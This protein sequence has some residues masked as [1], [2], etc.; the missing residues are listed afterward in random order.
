MTDAAGAPVRTIFLGSG[1]FAVPILD[2]LAEWPGATIVGVVTTPARPAG[3][4][5]APRP[6]PIALRAEALGLPVLTPDRLRDPAAHA[7]IA[8]LRPDL[9]VL[10]DYGRIVP[11]AL[12]D[13][14]LHGALN[15]HPSLLPRHRG[16]TPIPA[17]IAAGDAQ[18][19]VSLMRMDAGVDTGPLIARTVV[20]LDGTERAPELERRL[21]DVAAALLIRSLPAWLRG[22]LPAVPQDDEGATLTRPHRREDARLDPA[23]SADQLERRIRAFQP[24]PGAWIDH[25]S[26]RLI[27]HAAHVGPPAPPGT[28]PGALVGIGPDIALVTADGTLILDTVQPAGR[29]PM[30]GRDHRRGRRDL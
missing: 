4:D 25:P 24:W 29:R 23:L 18:T 8:A 10:A 26:G 22:E 1:E 21:A 11:Q 15:L 17:A 13:L 20:A 2:A 27:V 14:P 5:G 19:G 9:A 7:A 6:T 28:E 30:P 3:R 16:A 12:L